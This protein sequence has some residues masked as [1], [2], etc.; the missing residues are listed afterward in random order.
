MQ[1]GT[2]RYLD[3]PM[4]YRVELNPID[5]RHYTISIT[6]PTGGRTVFLEGSVLKVEMKYIEKLRKRLKEFEVVKNHKFIKI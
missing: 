4:S 3:V 2:K 6:S 5:K 1:V